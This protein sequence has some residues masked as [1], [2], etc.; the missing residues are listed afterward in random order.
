MT[1]RKKIP[2]LFQ[3][4]HTNDPTGLL[5]A[6]LPAPQEHGPGTAGWRHILSKNQ[7]KKT[8]LDRLIVQLV[9]RQTS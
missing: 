5:H 6:D 4:P 2:A 1:K 7:A 3:L 8:V 9:R